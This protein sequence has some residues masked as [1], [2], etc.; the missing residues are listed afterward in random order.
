VEQLVKDMS[1]DGSAPAGAA[2]KPVSVKLPPAY[3]RI[4]DN[5]AS[6]FSTKVKLERKKNGRGSIFIEFYNDED[7]ER[8]MAKM[9]L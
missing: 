7:L 1:A 5:M 4:E 9:S 2:A 6:H 3:K 8:I